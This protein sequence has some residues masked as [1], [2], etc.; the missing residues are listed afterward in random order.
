MTIKDLANEINTI[1]ENHLRHMAE[2]I[3]R[4]EK[5]VERM[6][7]R[8]WAILLILVTAVVMPQVVAFITK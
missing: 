2:D 1:K 4:I 7:V 6:D 3:D 5:K 8:L